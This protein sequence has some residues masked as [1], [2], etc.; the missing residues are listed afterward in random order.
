MRTDHEKARPGVSLS[1][2]IWKVSEGGSDLGSWT[3]PD[4]ET[5]FIEEIDV[6]HDGDI[7]VLDA[8]NDGHR[9]AT[10]PACGVISSCHT[11][12]CHV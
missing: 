10:R 9:F 5:A 7:F 6:A 4:S 11:S 1:I 12:H 2:P 8:G 3:I